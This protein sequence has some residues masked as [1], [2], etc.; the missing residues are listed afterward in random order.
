M[1]LNVTSDI[2][3]EICLCYMSS[4]IIKIHVTIFLIKFYSNRT[5]V[6]IIRTISIIMRDTDIYIL[7]KFS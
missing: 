7:Q 5:N 3:R 1:R 2:M 6:E 4:L